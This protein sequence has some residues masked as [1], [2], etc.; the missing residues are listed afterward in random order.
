MR[1]GY[2]GQGPNVEIF[3]MALSKRLGSTHVLSV[4]SG[5]SAIY[6]AL[7]LAGVEAGTEVISTPMTCT[8]T[9]VPIL[10]RGARTV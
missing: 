1:S 5:T 10:E 6:L 7:R 3:E 4:N 9:N 2:I 8:A